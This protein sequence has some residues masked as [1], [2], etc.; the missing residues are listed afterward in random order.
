MGL[1]TRV[2]AGR[3]PAAT[4]T[5]VMRVLCIGCGNGTNVLVEEE[6]QDETPK[7][8]VVVLCIYFKL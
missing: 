8:K 5:Y 7:W 3:D 6:K 1:W 2:W 4:V